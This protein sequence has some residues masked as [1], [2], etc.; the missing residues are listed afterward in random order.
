VSHNLTECGVAG[1]AKG[2]ARKGGEKKRRGSIAYL[3][4]TGE[5]CSPTD[6]VEASFDG[7]GNRRVTHEIGTERRAGQT[8]D[9]YKGGKE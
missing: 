4:P 1:G 8:G 3:F 5:K 9:A 7:L 6:G 2:A